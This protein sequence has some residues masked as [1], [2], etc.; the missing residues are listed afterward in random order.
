MAANKPL[1]Q[2]RP[3]ALRPFWRRD[4]RIQVWSWARRSGKSF[5]MAAR[6]LEENMLI[7]STQTIRYR[8]EDLSAKVYLGNLLINT[9]D[10]GHL[11][12]PESKWVQKDWRLVK[13]DRG[14]FTTEVDSSGAH[15]DTFDAAK[16]SLHGLI[17]AGGPAVAHAVAVGHP[18][19]S[20]QKTSWPPM[21]PSRSAKQTPRLGS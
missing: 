14:S 12:I 11:W 7:S 19:T 2:L 6:A 13:R 20:I 16:L 10:D 3:W 17:S 4:L 5:S 9:L 1:I 15:G 8:G 18:S 21:R